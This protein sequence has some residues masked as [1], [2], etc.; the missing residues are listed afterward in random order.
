MVCGLVCLFSFL[1]LAK[2]IIHLNLKKKC[3][4][5]TL[6]ALLS[7]F[8]SKLYKVF[9]FD[10]ARNLSGFLTE[11]AGGRC[12]DLMLFKSESKMAKK[13][14]SRMFNKLNRYFLYRMNEL[15]RKIL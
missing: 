15:I 7:H 1:D 9:A 13:M 11:K 2:E 14:E 8:G 12:S 5:R 6:N 3:S 10:A 4:D